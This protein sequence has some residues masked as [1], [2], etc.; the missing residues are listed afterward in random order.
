MRTAKGAVKY[1]DLCGLTVGLKCNFSLDMVACNSHSQETETGFFFFFNK[2]VA[3]IAS[4][5]FA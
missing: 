1:T 5:R 2:F 3:Y 4:V